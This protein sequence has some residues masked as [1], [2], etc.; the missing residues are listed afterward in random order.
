MFFNFF[1]Q[2]KLQCGENICS[3]DEQ[4]VLVSM[5]GTA[6]SIHTSCIQSFRI[7]SWVF[8]CEEFIIT[9]PRASFSSSSQG[10]FPYQVCLAVGLD[11]LSWWEDLHQGQLLFT[12]MIYISFIALSC[13]GLCQLYPLCWPILLFWLHIFQIRCMTKTQVI[14]ICFPYKIWIAVLQ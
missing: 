12:Y 2:C 11:S 7:S 6:F 5:F 4:I 14:K 13:L 3:L 1:L 9:S 10:Q 8:Q